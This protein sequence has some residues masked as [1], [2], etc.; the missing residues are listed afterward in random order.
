LDEEEGGKKHF[1]EVE[2]RRRR[3]SAWRGGPKTTPAVI[4]SINEAR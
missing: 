2:A 3:R 1:Q 4:T